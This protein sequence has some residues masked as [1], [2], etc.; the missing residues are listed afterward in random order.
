MNENVRE[1]VSRRACFGLFAPTNTC[2]RCPLKR[3]CEKEM[4][5]ESPSDF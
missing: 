1:Y 2:F 5:D 4:N 3:C